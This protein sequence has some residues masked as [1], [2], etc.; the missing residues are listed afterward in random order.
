MKLSWCLTL[1]PLVTSALEKETPFTVTANDQFDLTGGGIAKLLQIAHPVDG[2]SS[3]RL[4]EDYYADSDSLSKYSI[5]FQGC[6]HIQQWNEDAEEDEDVKISTTRLVRFRLVPYQQ[7]SVVSPWASFTSV[8]ALRNSLGGVDY[9]EYIVDLN[10]F[11]VSYMEAKE[12]EC[13]ADAYCSSLF[14]SGDDDA[15]NA[16]QVADYAQCAQID[17]GYGNDDAGDDGD[18]AGGD[19]GDN[20]QAFYYGPYCASQGGEIR[21][22]L[23]EDDS[24]TTVSTCGNK[25]GSSSNSRGSACYTKKT[26]EILPF[27]QSSIITDPCI[28][29]SQNYADLIAD[30]ALEESEIDF[31]DYDFGYARDVCSYTYKKSGK[32]ETYMVDGQYE[33]ACTYIAGIRMGVSSE[34]FAVAVRRSL[35]A[36]AVMGTMVIVSTFIGMYVY[37]LKHLLDSPAY[38]GN[39]LVGR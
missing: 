19:N 17:F 18:D 21:F 39:V 6:H 7:C 26:G 38:K 35:P 29:C 23:F 33:G 16:I 28:S 22:N 5:Q 32:C 9:G 4:L 11:V 25:Y 34:G 14:Y 2:S 1:L 8:Q 37:Y 36:D 15:G 20:N 24:C 27:T 13:D 10:S 31:S 3:S 30:E 12:E